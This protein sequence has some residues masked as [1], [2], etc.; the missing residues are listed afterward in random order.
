[1]QAASLI[2]ALP[3][4]R[5]RGAG[6]LGWSFLGRYLMISVPAH[7]AWETAQ[8]PLYTLGMEESLAVQVKAVLHCTAGDLMIAASALL[9]GAMA[10]R[11][12]A[13]R[14]WAG[15]T[16]LVLATSGGLG[17]TIFSEWLNTEVLSSWRYTSAM[18]R[19]PPFGTGLT[20]AMQWLI[21]PPLLMQLSV[22]RDRKPAKALDLPAPEGTTREGDRPAARLSGKRMS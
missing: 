19:L 4:P 9:G 14:A 15:A 12:L 7:L 18:P 2:A 16:C 8:V 10:A 11:V 1:M 22:R 20:P 17:Y 6:R 21:L 3:E 5:T 13:P